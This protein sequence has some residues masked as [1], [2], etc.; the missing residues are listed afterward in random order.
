M[1]NRKLTSLAPILASALIGLSLASPASAGS[2]RYDGHYGGW[3]TGSR[4]YDGT[5]A[6]RSFQAQGAYGGAASLN[7]SCTQGAGC[8][9]NWNRTLQNGKT[10]SGTVHAQRGQGVTRSGTGFRGRSW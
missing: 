2:W 3:T 5:T 1:A 8:T 9:R 7:G 6:S 10:A 4:S